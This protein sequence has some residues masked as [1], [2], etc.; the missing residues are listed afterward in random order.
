MLNYCGYQFLLRFAVD[1]PGVHG[2]V[3]VVH[4]AANGLVAQAN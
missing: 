1:K 4:E 3:V 2:T